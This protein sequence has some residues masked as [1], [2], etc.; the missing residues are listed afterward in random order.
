MRAWSLCSKL[1]VRNPCPASDKPFQPEIVVV[2]PSVTSR[3]IEVG[4]AQVGVAGAPAVVPPTPPALVGARM[5]SKGVTGT[6]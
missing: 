3:V 5:M 4:C 6:V 2:S 1:T